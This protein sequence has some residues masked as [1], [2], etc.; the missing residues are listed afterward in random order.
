MKIK[1]KS[2]KVTII[3]RGGHRRK[4]YYFCRCS[5]FI[6]VLVSCGGPGGRCGRLAPCRG[7]VRHDIPTT[8]RVAGSHLVHMWWRCE[9]TAYRHVCWQKTA[10]CADKKCADKYADSSETLLSYS[11]RS[12]LACVSWYS[13]FPELNKAA[14]GCWNENSLSYFFQ[15]AGNSLSSSS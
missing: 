10:V 6:R 3:M 1:S 2:M 9:L 14:P 12:L 5:L 4:H 15:P 11:A 13:T 7:A 8:P